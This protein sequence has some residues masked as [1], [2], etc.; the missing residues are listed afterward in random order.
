MTLLAIDDLVVEHRLESRGRPT[1]AG[2][3]RGRASAVGPGEVVGLVGESGCGKSTPG[4]RGLRAQAGTAGSI[5]FD[6]RPVTAA[7][8]APPRPRS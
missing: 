4:P 7:R 1:G 6:G 5:T 8:A 2:G 3:R